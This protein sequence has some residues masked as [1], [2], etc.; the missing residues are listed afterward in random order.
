MEQ[1]PAFLCCSLR[2][3]GAGPGAGG[4]SH[5]CLPQSLHSPCLASSCWGWPGAGQILQLH[6]SCYFSCCCLQLFLFVLCVLLKRN[7]QAGF[8]PPFSILLSVLH[9]ILFRLTFLAISGIKLF[10]LLTLSL[11][12]ITSSLCCASFDYVYGIILG[13]GIWLLMDIRPVLPQV[14]WGN[15]KLGSS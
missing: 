1:T 6:F 2:W 10:S 8:S 9:G 3:P 4:C 13:P 12:V 14:W 15:S 5:P 11:R 7:T